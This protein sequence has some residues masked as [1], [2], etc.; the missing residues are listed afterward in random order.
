MVPSVAWYSCARSICRP[1]GLFVCEAEFRESYNSVIWNWICPRNWARTVLIVW[2]TLIYLEFFPPRVDACSLSSFERN[3]WGPSIGTFRPAVDYIQIFPVICVSL[4]F[5]FQWYSSNHFGL[6]FI[7][8]SFLVR[9]VFYSF[10][11]STYVRYS[12]DSLPPGKICNSCY[13]LIQMNRV[14]YRR[15]F[16]W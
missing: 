15:K 13:D 12:V 2:L 5:I 6:F 11:S 4:V 10:L 14:L 3:I 1:Q 8:F 9:F 16:D 7:S